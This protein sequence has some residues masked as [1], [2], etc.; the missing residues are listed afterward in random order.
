MRVPPSASSHRAIIAAASLGTATALIAQG[1]SP[2]PGVSLADE[3]RALVHA[4]AQGEEARKRSE[5]LEL[6]AT[7]A[8]QKAERTR[9]RVA[10]LAARIQQ[11]EADLRAGQARI[12]IIARLQRAQ[13]ARLAARQGPIVRLTAALQQLARRSPI[14][15][16]LQP[17]SVP[18]AVHRRIILS[19]ML[20]LILERTRNLRAEIAKSAELRESAEAATQGM[21]K[22]RDTLGAQRKTLAA[23]AQRQRV[24]SRDFQTA[25]SIETERA[26]ALGEKARDVGQLMT[27]IQDA[28]RV[29]DALML[30][31]GPSLRPPAPG[32]T[33]LPKG[34][35]P[36]TEASDSAPAY[37]LPVIGN[38]VTGFG[39]VSRQG[40]RARG[41]TI[42][43]LPFATVVAPA[44]GRISFA[45]QFRN[46]GQIIIIDHGGGW[47]SL[48][49][50]MDKLL[51]QVGQS[52]RQGDPLGMAGSGRPRITIELRRG[53]RP[54]DIAALMR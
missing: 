36:A 45:G 38:V 39:E 28:G 7:T 41:L 46:Y 8:A 23:L 4:K 30:L 31:P 33:L 18:D 11:S 16:L 25:A 12:A 5:D 22:A 21:I 42:A 9:D 54:I 40:V 15:A 47:T 44:A 53:E 20:P 13:T 10:A 19:H 6:R 27:Q 17:G 51:A 35:E 3:Q 52:V 37:R 48:V 32:L 50:N 43:T 24:A 29:S 14:L 49:T 34:T 2:V 1:P 26:L